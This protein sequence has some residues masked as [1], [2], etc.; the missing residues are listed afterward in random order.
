MK[1]K[2]ALDI[3]DLQIAQTG[4]KTYLNELKLIWENEKEP[5]IEFVFLKP[6]LSTRLPKTNLEKIIEHIRF[7]IWKQIQLPVLCW[8]KKIDVL[9]CTDYFLPILKHRKLKTAVVFH[10]AFFAEYPEHY[11][12]IWLKLF[13]ILALKAAHKADAIITPSA[14]VKQ[15]VAYYYKFV[16]EKI[17]VVYEAPKTLPV[18]TTNKTKEQAN[19]FTI[20][21]V[22]TLDKRKNLE[23]LLRALAIFKTNVEVP[24]KLIL[25]GS[26][27]NKKN[28]HQTDKI[29]A[30]VKELNLGTNVE[31][32]GYVPDQLLPNYYNS[33]DLYVFP[34]INE[35][36]GLPILE[37]M[38]YGVPVIVA[39]NTCLPEIGGDAVLSFD[40]FNPAGLATLIASIAQSPE[41]RNDL[42]QK[43]KARVS[44][45]SWNKTANQL[46]QLF[47][48]LATEQNV[49]LNKI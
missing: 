25:V 21:H 9:F 20:L 36:F 24:V 18:A 5:A 34:S 44:Q 29:Y 11:N 23:T 4:A 45:F 2:I 26:S 38:Q 7:F 13:R 32:A 49:Y 39:N 8:I 30:L 22:G 19:L 1:L 17:H 15:R 41:L 37:A 48:K 12:R 27:A 33:A 16:Q 10:D 43:G 46:T 35:G 6:F 28:V 31:F 3:R 14:W 47:K 42:I 40:P